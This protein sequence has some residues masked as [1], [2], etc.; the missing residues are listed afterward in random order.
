MNDKIVPSLKLVYKPLIM[1][2]G[3]WELLSGLEDL[4]VEK[5]GKKLYDEFLNRYFYMPLSVIFKD[6]EL[7]KSFKC[8]VCS[9]L[10]AGGRT[11]YFSKKAFLRNVISNADEVVNSMGDEVYKD[12]KRAIRIRKDM[13]RDVISNGE[14]STYYNEV[15]REY[16]NCE[17]DI[18]FEEFMLL[19]KKKFTK[20]LSGY[21]AVIDLLD[22]SLDVDKFIKCFEADKLYLFTAYSLLENSKKYYDSFGRLDYNIVV[23]DT[24]RTLVDDLRKND[25][26]YNS[27]IVINDTVYTIDDLFKDYD[28]LLERV[29]EK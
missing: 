3:E 20:L 2:Y 5:K 26:F 15:K 16:L 10:G 14:D 23:L 7:A 27:Y 19:C 21:N 9:R 1:Y 18:S 4:S 13:Y 29:N 25:P 8:A 12:L 28:N 24:Y 11:L 22:K 17:L 6:E